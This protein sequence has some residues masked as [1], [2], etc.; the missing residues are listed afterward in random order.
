MYDYI[1][2]YIWL[3]IYVCVCMFIY[4]Y[5]YMFLTTYKLSYD[6]YSYTMCPS[7]TIYCPYILLIP[8][9]SLPKHRLKKLT[10]PPNHPPPGTA[11]PARVWGAL[12]TLGHIYYYIY[13]MHCDI[14]IYC[15]NCAPRVL[16]FGFDT[17]IQLLSLNTREPPCEDIQILKNLFCLHLWRPP[18]WIRLAPQR[19]LRKWERKPVFL[20]F[21][22]RENVGWKV[23]RKVN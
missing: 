4:I 7:V 20:L 6:I 2:I 16:I 14:I 19:N 13:S 5:I 9:L 21:K 15:K 23:M 18:V 12:G 1:H 17:P 3:Y 22:A 10:T 8:C 11:W